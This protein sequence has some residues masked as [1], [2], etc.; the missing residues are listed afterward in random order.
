MRRII[1]GFLGLAVSLAPLSASAGAIE[2]TVR[3]AAGVPL[4]ATPRSLGPGEGVKVFDAQGLPV[5]FVDV[6]GEAVRPYGNITRDGFYV[7]R[8]LPPGEY[9][10]EV[11]AVEGD[12]TGRSGLRC[13]RAYGVTVGEADTVRL[14]VVVPAGAG[15]ESMGEPRIPAGEG[16]LEGVVVDGEGRPLH[17][18]PRSFGPGEGVTLR[19]ASGRA[20][21]FRDATGGA[22]RAYANVSRRGHFVVRGLAPGAYEVYVNAVGR[23]AAVHRTLRVKRVVLQAGRRTVLSLRTEP[24]RGLVDVDAAEVVVSAARR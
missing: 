5:K 2:G 24:G 6:T 9:A 8:G 19:D 12:G 10:L 21:T 4:W 22:P 7:V 18:T 15:C 1:W 14:D 3:S 23:D 20:V 11:D 16:W 17:A 13:V